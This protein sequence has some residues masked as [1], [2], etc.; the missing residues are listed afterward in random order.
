MSDLERELQ[1]MEAQYE[2]E[3]GDGSDGEEEGDSQE[4]KEGQEGTGSL[5]VTNVRKNLC[6]GRVV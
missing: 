5:P 3:F 2:K 4:L 1:Q 6:E